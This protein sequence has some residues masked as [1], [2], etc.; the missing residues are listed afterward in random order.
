MKALDEY[1]LMVVFS[2]LL[3]RLHVFANF[4][5]N[6]NR[7]TWQ[8]SFPPFCFPAF[9]A[10]HVRTFPAFSCRRSKEAQGLVAAAL[11]FLQMRAV[12]A[13]D[14]ENCVHEFH[15]SDYLF[16]CFL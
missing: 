11:G 2:L 7:E 6:L 5:F 1:F 4:I 15:N 14:A 12:Y 10:L 13:S 16:V 3:N 8:R 9:P